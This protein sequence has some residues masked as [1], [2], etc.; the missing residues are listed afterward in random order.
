MWE[1]LGHL[2]FANVSISFTCFGRKG[3]PP[4]MCLPLMS[5]LFGWICWGVA[6]LSCFGWVGSYVYL[7][8]VTPPP[9][10]GRT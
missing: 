6:L 8:L 10:Q 4:C 3:Y 9:G 5:T 7:F 1:I 2:W